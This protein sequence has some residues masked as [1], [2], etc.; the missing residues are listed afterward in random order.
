MSISEL[1]DSNGTLLKSLM[2]R[3]NETR[4]QVDDLEAWRNSR[5]A[6]S[7]RIDVLEE[8]IKQLD[9]RCLG[10]ITELGERVNALEAWRESHMK[11]LCPSCGKGHNMDFMSTEGK[12]LCEH[13]IDDEQAQPETYIPYR[14]EVWF[15]ID[16]TIVDVI[17]GAI[18]GDKKWF[19]LRDQSNLGVFSVDTS[20]IVCQVRDL[21][22]RPSPAEPEPA[23]TRGWR[24]CT[25]TP[26]DGEAILLEYKYQALVSHE[27]STWSEERGFNPHDCRW[28]PIAE[29][30]AAI[31][32]A[33]RAALGE[34]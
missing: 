23:P 34:I 25:E 27:I 32:A 22:E 10:I 24:P 7:K 17:S 16:Q 9:G 18:L 29:V 26:K 4:Q 3:L 30:L 20:V 14:D 13:C 5:K 21:R 31:E 8:S 12:W 6:L 19:A 15:G 11:H 2:D 1:G 33:M 28:I